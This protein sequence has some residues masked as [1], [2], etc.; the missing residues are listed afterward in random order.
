[1]AATGRSFPGQPKNARDIKM[2][3]TRP[4]DDAGER[5][6]GEKASPAPETKVGLGGR[7]R[8]F[9]KLSCLLEK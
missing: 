8:G 3:P 4:T 2:G 1:M 9:L 6:Q 7:K 5:N